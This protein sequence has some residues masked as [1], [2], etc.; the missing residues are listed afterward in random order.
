MQQNKKGNPQIKKIHHQLCFVQYTK[1]KFTWL[2]FNWIFYQNLQTHIQL[3][4][5]TIFRWNFWSILFSFCCC[6]CCG[7]GCISQDQYLKRDSSCLFLSGNFPYVVAFC[8]RSLLFLQF[9][10]NFTI[11]LEFV[12][13]QT[14]LL[15][16]I[17]LLSRFE[18]DVTKLTLISLKIYL[19]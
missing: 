13:S 17:K 5:I 14:M 18:N 15:L 6:W 16:C 1:N 19:F 7:G 2:N 10:K 12:L 8:F 3:I 4:K 11:F 9:D